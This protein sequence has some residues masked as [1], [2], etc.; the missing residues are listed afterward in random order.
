[1]GMVASRF[2]LLLRGNTLAQRS[3]VFIFRELT[4]LRSY[5]KSHKEISY[6]IS[7]SM[8]LVQRRSV[9]SQNEQRD[10]PDEIAA[11]AACP[12]QQPERTG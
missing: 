4:F 3:A 6:I 5:C 11:A 1:M 2:P 10:I 12:R 8:A 7:K 9:D